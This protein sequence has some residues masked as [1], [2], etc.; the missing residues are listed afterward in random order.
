MAVA[1]RPPLFDAHLHIIDPRYPL[2]P[3]DGY[4]PPAFT[5]EDYRASTATLG[6]I[7]GAVVSGSFQ[8]FDQSYLL[9]ALADLGAGFVGVTQLPITTPDEQ[10][11][12]LAAA[13]V[14]AVRF[15]VRRGGSESLDQLDRL[16]RRVHDL[17]GW[18]TELYIDAA[19]LPDLT[20]TLS[21]LPRICIDHLGLSREGLPHLLR[22]VE[23]G[24][25]VKA[26][27]FS[28][29]DLDVPAALRDIAQANP[30]A[31]LAGT[32]L[33]STRAPRRFTDSDLDLIVDTLDD[34]DLTAAAFSDNAIALYR[35]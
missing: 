9:A 25:F 26:T 31:L 17:A 22:L 33:P 24:A 30:A 21:V 16:A 6:V 28:R 18:H 1:A 2:V 23:Q 12:A 5:T 27:G 19:D 4:L 20:G 34:L 3:N 29:G 32:D 13:G 8:R 7:G 10:I 35:P 14:R 15:N 11:R